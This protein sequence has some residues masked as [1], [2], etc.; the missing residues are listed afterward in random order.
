MQQNGAPELL[1]CRFRNFVEPEVT[2]PTG[3]PIQAFLREEVGNMPSLITLLARKSQIEAIGGFNPTLSFGSDLDWFTRA[4]DAGQ[5]IP[6]L[7]QILAERRL[8]DRNLTYS[9]RNSHSYLIDILRQ[10][11]RRKTHHEQDHAD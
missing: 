5:D 7:P 10:S 2:I 8:H 11:I 3:I 1:C 6:I 9:A 4:R